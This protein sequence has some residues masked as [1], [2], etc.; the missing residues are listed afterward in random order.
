MQSCQ[1]TVIVAAANCIRHCQFEYYLHLISDLFYHTL[2]LVP[3]NALPSLIFVADLHPGISAVRSDFALCTLL[4]YFVVFV[5]L[6][7]ITYPRIALVTFAFQKVLNCFQKSKQILFYPNH[8][9]L[10]F[11]NEALLLLEQANALTSLPLKW[12][13]HDV[14]RVRVY[15]AHSRINK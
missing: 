4:I 12:L 6:L 10:Y 7:F 15:A 14:G 13:Q 9:P 11:N 2:L 1:L 8:L 3:L 5:P